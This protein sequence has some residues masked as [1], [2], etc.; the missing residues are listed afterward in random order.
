MQT[1]Q[2]KRVI[3][4]NVN[5]DIRFYFKEFGAKLGHESMNEVRMREIF[6]HALQEKTLTDTNRRS[7]LKW[8]TNHP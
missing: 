6:N 1:M 7:I 3:F 4:R 5:D 8:L 2:V